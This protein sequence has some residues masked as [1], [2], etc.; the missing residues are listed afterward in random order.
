MEDRCSSEVSGLGILQRFGAMLF[1]GSRRAW[2]R[3]LETGCGVH[4]LGALG[5]WLASHPIPHMAH[6]PRPSLSSI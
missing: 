1:R 5:L 4:D 3:R 2:D 6:S